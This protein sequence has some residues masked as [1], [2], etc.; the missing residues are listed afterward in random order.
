MPKIAA[1]LKTFL[2]KLIKTSY[3]SSN[4]SK[5][6]EKTSNLIYG[7]YEVVGSLNNQPQSDDEVIDQPRALGWKNKEFCGQ[8][9]RGT[10]VLINNS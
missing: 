2:F 7:Y 4:S 8:S 9:E 10:K 6:S 3:K 5:K 1:T